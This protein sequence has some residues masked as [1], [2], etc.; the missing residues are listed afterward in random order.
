MSYVE[1]VYGPLPDSI[2]NA[3]LATRDMPLPPLKPI[4]AEEPAQLAAAE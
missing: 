3:Y 1:T 4:D 2:W